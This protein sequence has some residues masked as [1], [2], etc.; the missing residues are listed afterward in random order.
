MNKQ[1]EFYSLEFDSDADFW[2]MAGEAARRTFIVP[3]SNPVEFLAFG[4]LGPSKEVLFVARGQMAEHLGDFIA[5][6]VQ[7]QAS[8]ELY[9]RPPLPDS[10]LNSHVE[11]AH[12]DQQ[13]TQ[14]PPPPPCQIRHVV[15]AEGEQV[16]ASLASSLWPVDNF[17]RRVIAVP[18]SASGQYLA[19]G[20]RETDDAEY[21][22]RVPFVAWVDDMSTFPEQ[23]KALGFS[24]VVEQS[25][26]PPGALPAYVS[27]FN[28][29]LI[30]TGSLARAA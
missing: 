21:R 9:A 26:T 5:R 16:L 11:E 3:L 13:E 12:H 22:Y 18:L 30:G 15:T 6:M 17:P 23:M 7:A 4:V 20:L 19:F 29:S 27:A 10:I 1:P 28:Q 14:P 24:G 2:A 8:V 25:T